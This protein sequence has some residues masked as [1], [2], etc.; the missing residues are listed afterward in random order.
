[1]S[2]QFMSLASGSNGNCYYVSTREGA[3]LIDAGIAT[4]TIRKHLSNHH[5]ELEHVHAILVTHDHADHI[6]GLPG[7]GEGLHIP[8]YATAA[9][10]RG[11]AQNYCTRQKPL[12]TSAHTFTPGQPLELA[13]FHIEA[14]TLPHDSQDCVG[15]SLK[16]EGRHLVFM[17]DLGHIPDHALPYIYTADYLVLEAN[18]DEE[19][20]Q[21][22]SYPAYLK[23]RIASPT[24]HLSNRQAAT[25]LDQHF[26][27]HLRHLW[28]CH[29]SR[30]NN[31]PNRAEECIKT[32]LQQHLHPDETPV[33]VEA[34]Q[35]TSPSLLYELT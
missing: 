3:L 31:C 30:E 1:M 17:T 21:G 22:G 7:L 4:R 20:L 10:H 24:G 34:L 8:I 15:Y 5:L 26:P 19:M 25:L 16:A 12:N 29:L 33:I 9:T 23:A 6:K 11:I 28:L 13:G 35:R 14:F 32:I 2:I 18:Y 27:P